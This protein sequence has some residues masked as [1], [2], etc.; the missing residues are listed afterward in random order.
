MMRRWVIPLAIGLWGLSFTLH[1]EDY[2]L[3]AQ[4]ASLPGSCSLSGSTITCNGNLQFT[5]ET[6]V[7]ITSPLTLVIT[8]DFTMQKE[9]EANVG[10][11]AAS[12][13]IDARSNVNI[14]KEAVINA[15]MLVAGS[16]NIN[17]DTNYNGDL[18]ISGNL[19]LAKDSEINGDIIAASINLDKDSVI[20]GN[21][22]AATLNIGNNTIINGNVN[23]TGSLNNNGTITGYVNAPC[24]ATESC[25][26]DIQG[27]QCDENSNVGPCSGSSP[28]IDHF[29]LIHSTTALTCERYNV[30]VIACQNADCSIQYAFSGSV[31]VAE[32]SSG[33]NAVTA[34]FSNAS[35]SQVSLSIP[36]TGNYT[37]TTSNA[38]P[39]TPANPTQCPGGCAVT[40]TDTALRFSGE[41]TQSSGSN[42]VLGLQ[43]I[44]TDSETGACA[45][46]LSDNHPVTF[47][48][49]CI[50]PGSCSNTVTHPQAVMTV[51]GQPVSDSGD[52]V[53]VDFGSDGQANLSVAYG[54]AGQIRLSAATTSNE[55]GATLSGDSLPFAVVP[56]QLI[57]SHGASSPQIA[58]DAFALTVE[59]RGNHNQATP[60]YQPGDLQIRLIKDIPDG[61]GM[62]GLLDIS[63]TGTFSQDSPGIFT[64]LDEAALSFSSGISSVQATLSEVGTYN[65]SLIDSNY[66]SASIT[67]NNLSL[68]RFIPAYFA[69]TANVPALLDTCT[70]VS[71]FSYMGEAIGFD[72]T[73]QLQPAIRIEARNQQDQ[74]TNN[75]ANSLW[76]LG[77]WDIPAQLSYSDSSYAETLTANTGA[78]QLTQLELDSYDG[79]GVYRIDNAT[80]TYDK[81][82]TPLAPLTPS[83]DLII[84]EGALT[85]ADGVC[86]RTSADDPCLA[87]TLGDINGANLRYGRAN[88]T[89]AYGQETEPLPLP[90]IVEYYD[91]SDWL[92]NSDDNCTSYNASGLQLTTSLTTTASGDGVVTGGRPLVP[93]QGFVLSASGEMGE[94]SVEWLDAPQ[95]LQFDWQGDGMAL[96]PPT[97]VATFGQYRGND[98]IIHWREIFE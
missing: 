25:N 32:T 80:L 26:G 35:Q 97:S 89:N 88:L 1:A 69:V 42:F 95:W 56:T 86:F 23:V 57:L 75:Y 82:T 59:A 49:D 65:L 94:V 84:S 4:T 78:Q 7:F 3:P 64:D 66:F 15:N 62:Q 81:G 90:L 63:G 51:N 54:D 8:G 87:F 6:R 74:V 34:S 28:G 50:D 73:N 39:E 93:M 38:T 53:E 11:N 18:T 10:G 60:N 40:A 21:I 5:K 31:N 76:R 83:L 71:S 45:S 47:T 22:T 12:L 61:E 55:T 20:N 58:G 17:K 13:T 27:V 43:A 85:D 29:R 19:S 48:L 52:S 41:S 14:S 68:G 24:G 2:S 9:F 72:E 67:S 46:A 30:N 98:R 37:L 33:F 77:G 92:R 91:G 36:V 96:S 70:E 79:V 44:R 16:V